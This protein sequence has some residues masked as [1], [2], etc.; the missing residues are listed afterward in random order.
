MGIVT[1]K[2]ELGKSFRPLGGKIFPADSPAELIVVQIAY[3]E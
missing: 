2:W 3:S 1:R